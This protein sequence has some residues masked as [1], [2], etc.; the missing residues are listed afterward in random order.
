MPSSFLSLA[1][2]K[3]TYRLFVC[4]IVVYCFGYVS[5]I[6]PWLTVTVLAIFLSFLVSLLC[7]IFAYRVWL[8]AC[9]CFLLCWSGIVWCSERSLLY[10]LVH[11][12]LFLCNSAVL[13]AIMG[14]NIVISFNLWVLI[15]YLLFVFFFKLINQCHCHCR[16]DFKLWKAFVYS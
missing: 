8:L 7:N 16:G 13:H 2:L 4:L 3:H 14:T 10:V 5:V 11:C 1:N 6:S 9:C 15:L 12:T